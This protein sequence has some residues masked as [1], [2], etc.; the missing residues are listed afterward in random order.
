MH[1]NVIGFGRILEDIKTNKHAT[2][3]YFIVTLLL[4]VV[5]VE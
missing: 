2:I 5:K 4:R 3:V 1:F